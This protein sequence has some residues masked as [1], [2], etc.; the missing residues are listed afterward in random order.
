MNIG[1]T[2]I[3]PTFH[4]LTFHS[5]VEWDLVVKTVLSP[6]KTH[7]NKRYGKNRVTYI[8]A[9]EKQIIEIHAERDEINQIIWVINAFRMER[10]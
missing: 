1:K 2:S 7:E 9:S 6:T 3:R 4:Y 8:K 10:K 5:D